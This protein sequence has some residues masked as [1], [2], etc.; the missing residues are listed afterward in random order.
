MLVFFSSDVLD[1]AQELSAR[2]FITLLSGGAI[3]CVVSPHIIEL[4]MLIHFCEIPTHAS[5]SS[6]THE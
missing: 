2:E 5:V 3:F 6:L 4:A 1:I